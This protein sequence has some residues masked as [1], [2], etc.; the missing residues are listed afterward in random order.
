M[1]PHT[2]RKTRLLQFVS[3]LALTVGAETL[4]GNI[5]GQLRK[6]QPGFKWHYTGRNGAWPL[7]RSMFVEKYS[8]KL[9]G[10]A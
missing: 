3:S 7:H 8:G 9:V 6:P 4:Q 5:A 1:T 2:A 10:V